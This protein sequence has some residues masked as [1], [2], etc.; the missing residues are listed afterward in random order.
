MDLPGGRDAG[1][2]CRPCRRASHRAYEVT[3]REERIACSRAHPVTAVR[4]A[5]YNTA[6]RA[7]PAGR[8]A[9]ARHLYNEWRKRIAQRLIS[10]PLQIAALEAELERLVTHGT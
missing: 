9:A 7:T 6:Y 8:E 4:H 10:K 1:G 3:H 5:A 2:K